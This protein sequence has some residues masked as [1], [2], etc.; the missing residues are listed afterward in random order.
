MTF[1]AL[2]RQPYAGLLCDFLR[3]NQ[4]DELSVDGNRTIV[5]AARVSKTWYAL[6][7]NEM[8][9]AALRICRMPF[10][11]TQN[12]I[13][14]IFKQYGSAQQILARCRMPQYKKR[15]SKKYRKALSI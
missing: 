1:T 11:E 5:R 2:E 14:A 6:F 8:K 3:G 7:K 4:N 9:K 13:V 12:L 15:V 10:E